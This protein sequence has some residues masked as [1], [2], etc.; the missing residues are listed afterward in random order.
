[1]CYENNVWNM[2]NFSTGCR[3]EAIFTQWIGVRVR[4]WFEDKRN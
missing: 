3:R 1:M 2:L 4:E